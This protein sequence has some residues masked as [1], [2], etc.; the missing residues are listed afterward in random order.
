MGC[1]QG[2]RIEHIFIEFLLLVNAISIDP[3]QLAYYSSSL[4]LLSSFCHL[5]YFAASGKLSLLYGSKWLL[6]ASGCWGGKGEPLFQQWKMASCYYSHMIQHV[7][8]MSIWLNNRNL[9]NEMLFHTD[10]LLWLQC[11]VIFPKWY[12][13]L[14]EATNQSFDHT[15]FL[16]ERACLYFPELQGDVSWRFK[17]WRR[18]NFSVKAHKLNALCSI[19]WLFT[20]SCKLPVLLPDE[21]QAEGEMQ[22]CCCSE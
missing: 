15:N 9:P 5:S 1:C 11:A 22:K 8:D 18:I 7:M 3:S 16:Q 20:Q 4:W 17:Q 2:E 19:A 10:L 21:Q 12:H 13:S 14:L 6:I